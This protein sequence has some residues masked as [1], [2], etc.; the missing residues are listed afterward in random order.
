VLDLDESCSMGV[1]GFDRFGVRD[2]DFIWRNAKDR[3]IFAVRS[4]DIF[5]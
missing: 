4:S 2:R 5:M 1:D 3:A